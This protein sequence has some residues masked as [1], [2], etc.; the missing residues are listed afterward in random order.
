M[1]SDAVGH[2]LA[3]VF[4]IF[5]LF[6]LPI[7]VFTRQ[8][9]IVSQNVIDNAVVEFKDNV[10]GTGVIT[11]DAFEQ[12]VRKIDAVQ[13][14]CVITITHESKYAILN[15]SE[16]ETFYRHYN[17]VEI[18][19]TIYPPGGPK[20]KYEMKNGDRISVSV[21]N[22]SPTLATRLY[23][24]IAP[25]SNPKGITIYSNHSGMVGNNPQY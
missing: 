10:A 8:A 6:F 17:K 18:L 9:D 25:G 14:N 7:L 2:L 11:A 23:R 5:L 13:P 15:G 24:I 1:L 4:G 20:Q 16:V 22:A 3:F 21:Y 19:N 12:L